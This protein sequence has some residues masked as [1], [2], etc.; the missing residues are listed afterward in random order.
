MIA[1][2]QRPRR[3]PNAHRIGGLARGNAIG[4]IAIFIAVS[5]TAYAAA[6]QGKTPAD[7][8][9]TGKVLTS[10]WKTASSCGL[11]CASNATLMNNGTFDLCA[12]CQGNAT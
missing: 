2:P 3:S 9:P 6:L 5:G 10:G 7:F 8:L 12:G 1:V 11:E 4:L